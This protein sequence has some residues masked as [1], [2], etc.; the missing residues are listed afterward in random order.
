M[1]RKN[2]WDPK[3]NRYRAYQKGNRLYSRSGSKLALTQALD[4]ANAPPALAFKISFR[5]KWLIP[6]D[7]YNA[8]EW[9]RSRPMLGRCKFTIGSRLGITKAIPIVHNRRPTCDDTL[10]EQLRASL[11]P[12]VS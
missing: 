2:K 4:E 10:E 1:K 8:I 11:T 9:L 3:R 5:L 6:R 7:E 12:K